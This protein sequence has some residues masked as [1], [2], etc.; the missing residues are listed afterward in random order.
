MLTEVEL[1]SAGP[2][3]VA[4]GSDRLVG[5]AVQRQGEVGLG[6]PG[7]EPVVEHRPGAVDGLLG[8]LADQDHGPR[9]AV[10]MIRQPAGGADEAGHVDVVPAGVHHADLTPGLVACL[11]LAGVGQP[12]LLDDRQRVHVGADQ[13]DRPVAVLQD[14]D[15]AELADARRHL[16][17]G[18]RQLVGDPLRRFDLLERELGVGVQVRVEGDQLRQ[19]R[20]DPGIRRDRFWRASA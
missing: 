6:E 8:R 1:A 7:V 2:G 9:P 16:G 19:A 3:A 18:F 10:P 15:D 17:A 14:A 20:G 5:P 13:H 4:H 11:H 12:G